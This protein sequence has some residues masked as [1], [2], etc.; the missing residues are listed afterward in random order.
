MAASI[1]ARR[2]SDR[3]S[4][5]SSSISA[6]RRADELSPIRVV[7]LPHHRLGRRIRRFGEP[8]ER[9]VERRPGASYWRASERGDRRVRFDVI[10]HDRSTR[11]GRTRPTRSAES[12]GH[13]RA[14]ISSPKLP[15][16]LW[17]MCA[18]GPT[19]GGTSR[20]P[21]AQVVGVAAGARVV[22]GARAGGSGPGGSPATACPDEPGTPATSEAPVGSGIRAAA[23]PSPSVMRSSV[24]WSRFAYTR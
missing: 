21:P 3:R 9:A 1:S 14:G 11:A 4:E 8:G 10:R 12:G 6:E 24:L 5:K 18:S 13:V 23:P 16:E 2:S 7:V 15:A 22:H 20:G 19:T 17:T